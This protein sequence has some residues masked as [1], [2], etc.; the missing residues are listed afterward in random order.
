[1]HGRKEGESALFQEVAKRNSTPVPMDGAAFCSREEY[2]T[3]VIG[4]S[5]FCLFGLFRLFGLSGW[6]SSAG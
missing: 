4:V 6:F 2:A 3:V 5:Q 1:M